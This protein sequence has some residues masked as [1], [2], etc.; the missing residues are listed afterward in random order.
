MQSQQY[1]KDLPI[2]FP[3]IRKEKKGT[4]FAKV[5]AVIIILIIF[6][7]IIISRADLTTNNSFSL[8]SIIFFV[9]SLF[10]ILVINFFAQK[11][12]F[13]GELTINDN[14]ITV[15]TTNKSA[16]FALKD[17][18][19][20]QINFDSNEFSAGNAKNLLLKIYMWFFGKS[21]GSGNFISFKHNGENYKFGIYINTIEKAEILKQVAMGFNAIIY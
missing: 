12:K 10:I 5:V 7:K 21:G 1:L 16:V 9:V 14:D 19:N 2:V 8:K 4:S 20:L 11:F 15:K 6:I 3:I 13:G 18:S 17:I